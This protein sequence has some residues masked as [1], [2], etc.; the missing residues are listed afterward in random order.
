MSE[1]T[2]PS[3]VMDRSGVDTD[4][5]TFRDTKY[6]THFTVREGCVCPQCGSGEVYSPIQTMDM[7]MELACLSCGEMEAWK[8]FSI[9]SHE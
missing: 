9:D 8:A 7:P 1:P 4:V 3:D 2:R 5:A 6:I